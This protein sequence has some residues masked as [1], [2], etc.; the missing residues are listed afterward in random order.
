MLPTP[1]APATIRIDLLALAA[2]SSSVLGMG[3][4]R[5]L[6]SASQAVMVVRG[7]AAASANEYFVGFNATILSSTRT[8]SAKEPGL[9]KEPEKYTSSPTL[10]NVTLSPTASTIPAP[11]HPTWIGFS[12]EAT[13]PMDPF[14]T[15]V[16]TGLVA[17]AFTLINTS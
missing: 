2:F 6:M 8:E 9:V 3:M 1:P 12:S 16:S 5:S 17:T 11:S 4:T 7:R 14:N 10:N 15:L 13:K